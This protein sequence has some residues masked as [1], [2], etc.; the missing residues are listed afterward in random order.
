M[1]VMLNKNFVDRFNIGNRKFIHFRFDDSN[2]LMQDGYYEVLWSDNEEW[3]IKKTSKKY[4]ERI[5]QVADLGSGSKIERLFTPYNQYYLLKNNLAKQVKR[6]SQIRSFYGVNSGAIRK[7]IRE[8]ELDVRQ[9]KDV[10]FPSIV[11]FINSSLLP[12]SK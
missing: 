6:V 7:Y 12:E 3:L 10:A 9:N 2:I 11:K 1:P 8:N 5:N 4:E